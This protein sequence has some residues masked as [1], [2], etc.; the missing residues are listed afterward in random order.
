MKLLFTR[1]GSRTDAE[2]M[3]SALQLQLKSVEK[4]RAWRNIDTLNGERNNSPSDDYSYIGNEYLD[5]LEQPSVFKTL[6]IFQGNPTEMVSTQNNW[7]LFEL[8]LCRSSALL[9]AFWAQKPNW[10]SALSEE[11]RFI[12]NYRGIMGPPHEINRIP[13]NSSIIAQKG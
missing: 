2:E 4:C 6:W 10:W 13:W 1:T 5:I 12:G 9:S 11:G 3:P 7:K 8:I